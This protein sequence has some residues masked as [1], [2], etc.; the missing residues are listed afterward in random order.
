MLCA[1]VF[2]AVDDPHVS[3]VTRESFDLWRTGRLTIVQVLLASI[4]LSKVWSLVTS[5]RTE[6]YAS[7]PRFVRIWI[8][9]MVD[10]ATNYMC[11]IN[12]Y[13]DHRLVLWRHLKLVSLAAMLFKSKFEEI[14]LHKCRISCTSLKVRTPSELREGYS[15]ACRPGIPQSDFHGCLALNRWAEAM[16]S[17]VFGSFPYETI[18][19]DFFR[20]DTCHHFWRVW[21]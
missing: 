11:V 7:T 12:Q 13:I 14:C 2:S 5:G 1:E 6:R 21:Q 17:A 20:A 4:E 16:Q 8:D 3:T 15:D 18:L 9:W 19:I 10:V